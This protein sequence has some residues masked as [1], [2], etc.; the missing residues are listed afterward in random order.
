VAPPPPDGLDQVGEDACYRAMDWLL[1]VEAELAK[2]VYFATADLL[3][4]EVDLLF[5]DTTST[6]FQIEDPDPPLARGTGGSARPAMR[7]PD[8]GALESPRTTATTYRR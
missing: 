5:F 6:Y 4:L 7:R 2:E 1:Q 3:N 8:S